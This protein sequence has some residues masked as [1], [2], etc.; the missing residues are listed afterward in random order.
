V[1]ALTNR[2]GVASVTARMTAA[3][4]AVG[5]QLPAGAA[6]FEV[7]AGDAEVGELG[8]EVGDLGGIV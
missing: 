3:C 7:D 8:G 1:R 5:P 4:S 2:L 6:V